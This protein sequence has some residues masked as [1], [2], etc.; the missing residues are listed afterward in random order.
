MIERSGRR[1]RLLTTVLGLQL[2]ALIIVTP[3]VRAHAGPAL[4]PSSVTEVVLPGGSTEVQKT[5]HLPEFPPV[6]DLCLVQDETGSF[7]DDLP[8]M[9]TQ[10]PLL[11]TALN[12][13]GS[14]YA[15]CTIGFRDFAQDG[16]GGAA[17]WVYRKITDVTPAGA[18]FNV[19]ALTAGGGGDGPEG[20]LEALH[21]LADPAHPAI[22]SNGAAGGADTPAGQQPTWRANSQRLVLL[23]TDNA[24]HV[25]GDAGGWPGDAGTTSP[26]VTGGILAANNI[27]LIGLTP[28]GGALGL[29]GPCVSTLASAT[30]GTVQAIGASSETIAQAIL[31]ALSEIQVRV[32]MRSDCSNETGGVVTTTFSPQGQLAT[33]GDDVVFT[34]TISVA[35]NAPGGTYDCRD[36]AEIVTPDG[37][38]TNLGDNPATPADET[39]YEVKT[40]KVPEG[41]LTGG[42][43]ISNGNGPNAE[44]I[45]WGGN[46]GF[47]ADF[48]LVGEWN[49]NF[50]NV[51]GTSLD[52]AHFHAHEIVSLQ[53]SKDAGPGPNPPPANANV[54]MFVASGELDHTPGYLLRVCAADRGEPGKGNDTMRMQL[55]APGPTLVYDSATDFADQAPAT[56]CDGHELDGG[57]VQI[58]SGLKE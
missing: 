51:V 4:T 21:Y 30:G 52:G 22:D 19:G 18:G 10:I 34:E 15:T 23:A 39:I 57:N 2:A 13:S 1:T 53:F 14:D 36:W 35:A 26:A 58:H 37:T 16:W 27:T 28:L 32:F 25:T 40:I 11:V 29:P 49:T 55:F 7:A 6:F 3:V 31:D 48:S 8:N 42:G 38:A 9:A 47:L 43:H 41:F 46:A 12:A 5:A 56:A 33:G 17:D 45:S 54:A 24:C 44:R 20:Q 50:H